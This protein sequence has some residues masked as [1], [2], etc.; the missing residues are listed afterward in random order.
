MSVA[1]VAPFADLEGKPE[2]IYPTHDL[3]NEITYQ[4]AARV[5]DAMHQQLHIL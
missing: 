3:G 2:R 1:T 5:T 4:Q